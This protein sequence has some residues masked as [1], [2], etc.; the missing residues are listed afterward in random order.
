MKKLT[1]IILSVIMVFGIFAIIPFTASASTSGDFD[2]EILDDG[3]AELIAYTGKATELTIPS[4]LNGYKVTSIGSWSFANC[5]NLT[6]ITIPNTI[7]IINGHAFHGCTGLAEITIPDSVK[8]IYYGAFIDCTN[9]KVV[10]IGKGITTIS[11]ATFKNCTNITKVNFNATNCEDMGIPQACTAFEDCSNLTTLNFGNSVKIIPDYAFNNCKSLKN[12]HI[13]ASVEN[14]GFRA[15]SYCTSLTEIKLPDNIKNIDYG[16]FIGCSN[17]TNIEVS[18]KNSNYSSLNGNLYK[19][20][21]TELIQYAVGKKDTQL[22]IPNSVVSIGDYA[23]CACKTLTNLT[24]PDNVTHIGKE[25]FAYCENLTEIILSDSV[26]S[27]ESLAFEG[28]AWYEKQPKELV[29]VGKVAYE[30][31]GYKGDCPKTVVLKEGTTAIAGGAFRY[32]ENLTDITIP[33]SVTSIGSYAFEYCDSL[34]KITIPD[35]ITSIDDFAFFCCNSLTEITIPYSVTKIGDYA[36][37]YHYDGED[38]V[39]SIKNFKINGFSNT[40][41]EKYAKVNNIEFISLGSSPTLLGDVNCDGEVNVIDAT[42]IQKYIVRLVSFNDNQKSV[43]DTNGDGIITVFDATQIQKYIVNFI[44][45]L[46]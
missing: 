32:C 18:E 14:I 21:K 29:Y 36:V 17:L 26:T 39:V 46:D 40:A 25:A 27:I 10:T 35:S 44:E 28:T 5:E 16:A 37:G 30:Y 1:S 41:A 12:V 19:K 11:S 23:L 3:T 4:T 43:A 20:E 34:T 24:V 33:N 31:K 8:E 2:Y 45:S 6:N 38:E 42:E 7:T 15:F 22:I 9:L 13:P